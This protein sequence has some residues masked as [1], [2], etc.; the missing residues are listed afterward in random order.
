MPRCA[1]LLVIALTA[2]LHHT[3]GLPATFGFAATVALWMLQT[4][5]ALVVVAALAAWHLTTQHTPAHART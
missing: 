1:W 3:A 5:A 2:L 4:P